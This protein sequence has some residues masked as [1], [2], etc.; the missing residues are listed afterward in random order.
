MENFQNNGLINIGG[1]TDDEFY[2]YKMPP[3]KTQVTGRGNGIHTLLLN[4]SEVANAIGHPEDII[5]KYIAYELASNLNQKKKSLSGKHDTEIQEK[6]MDYISNL[7]LCEKCNNPETL[8]ESEGKKK[9]VKLFIKCSS[10]GFRSEIISSGSETEGI[11][12]I[13]GK[14][15][16]KILNNILRYVKENPVDLETKEKKEYIKESNL[17]CDDV[18]I[19]E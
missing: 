19:F 4:I 10:C 8:Y 2:R 6:I 16:L 18:D 9:K 3:I 14:N 7:V 17:T 12:V 5:M 11:K 13:K 1:Q 15:G